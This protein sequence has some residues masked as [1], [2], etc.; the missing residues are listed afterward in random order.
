MDDVIVDPAAKVETAVKEVAPATTK[1]DTQSGGTETPAS[2]TT[3]PLPFHEDPKIKEYLERQ[4]SKREQKWAKQF[5]EL[6]DGYTKQLELFNQQRSAQGKPEVNQLPPEQEQALKQLVDMLGP[7]LKEQLGIGKMESLE[8]QLQTMTQA[9]SREAF[10]SEMGTVSKEYAERYGYDAKQLD[11]DL[12]EFIETD[13]WFADKQYS[14]GS[15]KKAAALYF[16]EKG[17]E[18]AERAANLKLIKEQKEKKQNG[19]ESSSKSSVQKGGAKA[20]RLEDFLDDRVSEGG[21]I[22]FD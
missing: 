4:D 20:K 22:Q 10:E 5:Q 6:K 7:R 8:K 16:S 13:E 12:R 15:V 17:Q 21:G 11:E 18:L 14:K 3:T 2:G 1:P 9:G 19:T